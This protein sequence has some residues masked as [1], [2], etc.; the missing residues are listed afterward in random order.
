[1][2][3]SNGGRMNHGRQ[4]WGNRRDQSDQQRMLEKLE[5]AVI[6][7]DAIGAMLADEPTV[8]GRSFDNIER[9]DVLAKSGA[10]RLT[11]KS[12]WNDDITQRH[13]FGSTL[14]NVT[15][16]GKAHTLLI[17]VDRK[18]LTHRRFNAF[19]TACR[20]EPKTIT[21]AYEGLKPKA[22][23]AWEKKTGK[24]ALRQGEFFFIP[25][26]KQPKKK[27]ST[28][29]DYDKN[30]ARDALKELGTANAKIALRELEATAISGT[31]YGTNGTSAHTAECTFIQDGITYAKGK[32]KHPR[33]EHEELT[34]TTWHTVHPST[35]LKSITLGGAVD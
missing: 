26:T 16:A 2:V 8:R 34:L 15:C 33:D 11:I 4:T 22:I 32:V 7:F 21:Q 3:F 10:E 18:E 17:D 35:A 31:L 1:M 29:N 30:K 23:Q 14:L 27:T 19:I 6:P 12:R 28:M 24:P 13:F 20:G 9:I 5:T 25:C